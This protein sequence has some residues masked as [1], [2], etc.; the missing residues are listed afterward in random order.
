[1][2]FFSLAALLINKYPLIDFIPLIR[3]GESKMSLPF[4]PLPQVDSHVRDSQELAV[5]CPAKRAK[6]RST[7]VFI[8]RWV[9]SK[10]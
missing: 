7:K 5:V 3:A 2:L 4:L 8:L 9:K 6:D 10:C 1:M